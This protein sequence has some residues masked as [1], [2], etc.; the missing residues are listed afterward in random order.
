MYFITLSANNTSESVVVWIL[1]K[2]WE[3]RYIPCSILP[4][5][6][7]RTVYSWLAFRFSPLVL[8]A[9]EF[10]SHSPEHSSNLKLLTC[11]SWRHGKK[12]ELKTA[13]HLRTWKLQLTSWWLICWQVL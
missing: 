6:S 10:N 5:Y 11:P 4:A 9:T 7:F 3:R 1:Q 8:L 13:T 2:G 12:N